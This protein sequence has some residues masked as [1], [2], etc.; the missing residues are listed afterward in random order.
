[1]TNKL[2]NEQ[3]LRLNE[4]LE[5]FPDAKIETVEKL[6][7]E[8]KS[9]NEITDV[10]LDNNGINDNINT[11]FDDEETEADSEAK[12][13]PSTVS[14]HTILEHVLSIFPDIKK[15][16]LQKL[17]EENRTENNCE[18]S[19]L[20]IIADKK[21]DYPHEEPEIPPDKRDFSNV[22]L[23][24][25]SKYKK[26]VGNY[27]S[28]LYPIVPLPALT[29]V[30]N[31]HNYHLIPSLDYLEKNL[32]INGNR[33]TIGTKSFRTLT[34][35]RSSL[36]VES[37]V[38]KDFDAEISVIKKKEDENR[39]A[40]D[41]EVAR[42]MLSEEYKQLGGRLIECGCCTDEYPIEEMIQ[43]TEMHLICTSCAKESILTDLKNGK[44]DIKF[45][46]PDMSG[47][48]GTI[49]DSFVRRVLSEKE[50]EILSHRKQDFEINQ[51]HL[52]GLEKC[53]FCNYACI[54]EQDVEHNSEFHCANPE[55]GKVSCR[56]CHKLSH[57]PLSCADVTKEATEE[58]LRKAVEEAMDA[59]RIRYCPACS[60]PVV[61][62]DGCNRVPC[63]C[64]ASFCYVCGERCPDKDPYQ[65]FREGPCPL[66][67]KS[68]NKEEDVRVRKAGEEAEKKWRMEHPDFKDTNL[69]IKD[70]VKSG[71]RPVTEKNFKNIKQ[72]DPSK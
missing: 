43:C 60:K 26:L 38:D 28:N 46:C 6:I 48:S 19:I 30:L 15:D 50:Y 24:M 4:L 70:V 5:I 45:E 13:N 8:G 41:V 47:C 39:S 21:G 22:E 18:E 32:K 44:D 25:S 51:A 71:I 58:S 56:L 17:I 66:W 12:D 34:R 63:S 53:P 9:N 55:C 10:L 72:E 67:A 35:K 14:D 54:M 59:A 40:E 37:N 23:R 57:L 61:K 42:Q 29:T 33:V 31:K 49:P 65:H 1:M 62:L 2:T 68:E 36:P 7:L 69:I 52:T 27:V 64:G 16:Y 3:Q 11:Q 20:N